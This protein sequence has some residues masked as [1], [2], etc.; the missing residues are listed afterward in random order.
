[1][2][3]TLETNKALALK[4]AVN[5]AR[6]ALN[7]V[8]IPGRCRGQGMDGI[9]DGILSLRMFGQDTRFDTRSLTLTV[10]GTD[11]PAKDG[12]LVLLL[13]FLRNDFPVRRTGELI[14]FRD[15][16]G[17]Q[18]YYPSFL[19]RSTHILLKRFAHDLESLREN[20]DRLDWEPLTCGD[21]GAVVHAFGPLFGAIIFRKGDEEF[22]ATADFLFDSGVKRALRTEDAAVIATRICVALM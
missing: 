3:N 4:K 11:E 14:T 15:F 8:D 16:P 9:R 18:F 17:G 21:V 12:D 7:G 20:L 22:P 10:S 1:M 2:K 5:D 13:H 6:A 19:S